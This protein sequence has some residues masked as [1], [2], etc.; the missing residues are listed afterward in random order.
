MY[1]EAKKSIDESFDHNTI[2]MDT[3]MERLNSMPS[4]EELQNP[5]LM[6]EAIS[7]FETWKTQNNLSA[8]TTSTV[9]INATSS[10][11]EENKKPSVTGEV[12]F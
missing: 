4:V 8:N 12:D 2:E 5:I 7:Q 6:Q 3:L 9:A 10:K 11:P 1:R